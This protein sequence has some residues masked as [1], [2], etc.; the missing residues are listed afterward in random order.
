MLDVYLLGT[1]GTVPLP[2]RWLTSC[3]IRYNGMG[4]LFD[5]GEGTQITLHKQRLSCKHVDVIFLTHFHADHTA[6]LP[7]LLLSMAKAD[8][9]DPVLIIGPKG[10]GEILNGVLTLARGVPFEIRYREIRETAETIEFGD[11]SVTA[12]MVRHSVVC[13]GY[14]V[15]VKRA[16]KFDAEKAKRKGVPLKC[17]NRLQKGETVEY[18]GNTYTPDMVL[19]EA[20]KGLKMVYTTDTRPVQYINDHARNADLLILEG[21]YGDPDKLE[22][23]LQNRHMMMDEAAKIAADA[24][25]KE[26][27]L[28]H[29]SPSM[30]DPS[31]YKE[32]VQAIFRNT[33]ISRD[34]Q[35]KDLKFSD[36]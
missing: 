23:A 1:G 29:Y 6:G 24:N 34:G 9:T 35:H 11:L 30:P 18:E 13:Y 22:N 5:C 14:E 8:R 20:R 12:F 2:E 26:M 4:I 7:G 33:V 21:M 10:L 28:T 3:Y 31:V 15:N 25:V 27:W 32:E 17:W 36:D 16:P 19:G